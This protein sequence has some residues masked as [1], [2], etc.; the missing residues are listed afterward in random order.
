MAS[1]SERDWRSASK[2]KVQAENQPVGKASRRIDRGIH[3]E[4]PRLH[5]GLLEEQS[6]E[7]AGQLRPTW[8]RACTNSHRT[9][10]PHPSSQDGFVRG[11]ERWAREHACTYGCHKKKGTCL[12]SPS[13][14]AEAVCSCSDSRRNRAR[15]SVLRL[16]LVDADR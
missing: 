9:F 12:R 16:R 11:G 15:T 5:R 4:D 1:W 2:F 3:L 14:E 13:G 8:L 7:P 6:R 10:L